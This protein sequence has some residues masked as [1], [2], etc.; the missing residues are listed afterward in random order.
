MMGAGESVRLVL[1]KS[2]LAAHID[3]GSTPHACR[4]AISSAHSV[5]ESHSV[6]SAKQVTYGKK[7]PGQIASTTAAAI[8]S[9]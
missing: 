5:S 1:G 4:A 8:C 9:V 6:I 7:A 3:V 2:P